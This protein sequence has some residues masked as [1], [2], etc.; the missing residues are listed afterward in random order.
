MRAIESMIRGK[1]HDQSL[2]EDGIFVGD[3]IIA[4]DPLYLGVGS[5][6]T[7]VKGIMEGMMSFDDRAYVRVLAYC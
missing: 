5:G 4:E 2:C 1:H 7:G 6:R 3:K